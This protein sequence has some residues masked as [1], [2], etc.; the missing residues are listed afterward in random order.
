MHHR[1]FLS[2]SRTPTVTDT[3][4]EDLTL[5]DPPPQLADCKYAQFQGNRVTSYLLTTADST[6]ALKTRR[7]KRQLL[8]ASM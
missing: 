2:V 6:Q 3:M 8:S 7:L 4:N 5:P 1:A